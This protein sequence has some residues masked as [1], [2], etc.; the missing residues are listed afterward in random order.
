VKVMEGDAGDVSAALGDV[1]TSQPEAQLA[2][3]EDAAKGFQ[4]SLTHQLTA[5]VGTVNAALKAAVE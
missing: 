3:G 4:S 1:I 5:A 2:K